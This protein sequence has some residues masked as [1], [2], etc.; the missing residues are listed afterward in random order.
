[1]PLHH[2]ASGPYCRVDDE[3]GLEDKRAYPQA[4]R[5]RCRRP[6]PARRL[7]ARGPPHASRDAAWASN[8]PT[9]GPRACQKPSLSAQACC[10]VISVPVG[11][12]DDRCQDTR[13]LLE[14]RAGLDFRFGGRRQAGGHLFAHLT[15]HVMVS[16]KC[17]TTSHV[18]GRGSVPPAQP[19]DVPRGGGSD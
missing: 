16:M 10:M 8:G 18:L 7:G 14:W 15:V 19:P 9:I 12:I 3:H 13:H 5:R 6:H 2:T 1:M 17:F 4:R 11:M